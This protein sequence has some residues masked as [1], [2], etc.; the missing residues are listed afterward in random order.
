MRKTW[1]R[2][3]GDV[4]LKTQGNRS[5]KLDSGEW[6]QGLG[7]KMEREGGDRDKGRQREVKKQ[8]VMKMTH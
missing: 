8:L 7:G 1:Y 6:D 4:G 5:R 2:G 3:S